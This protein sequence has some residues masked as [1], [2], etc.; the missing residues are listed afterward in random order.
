[1]KSASAPRSAKPA[2][3]NGAPAPTEAN[4][5][6]QHSAPSTRPVCTI[7]W[8]CDRYSPASCARQAFENRLVNAGNAR[9]PPS[10]TPSAQGVSVVNEV[11]NDSPASDA[12]SSPSPTT[13]I[14]GSPQSR[15]SRPTSSP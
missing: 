14:V 10:A 13:V 8:L 3:R 5:Q 9:P 15:D 1:M 6:P 12:P 7:A 4:T 2:N 11:E